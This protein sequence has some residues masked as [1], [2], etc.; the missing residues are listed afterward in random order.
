MKYITVTTR[1]KIAVGNTPLKE[2]LE[3]LDSYFK[4]GYKLIDTSISHIIGQNT[5]ADAKEDK[6]TSIFI[7]STYLLLIESTN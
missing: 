6:P 2:E 1:K 5:T 3:I 4:E 7:I